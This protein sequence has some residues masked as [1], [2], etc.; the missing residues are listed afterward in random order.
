MTNLANQ[1]ERLSAAA[2]PGEWRTHAAKRG[3]KGDIFVPTAKQVQDCHHIARLFADK[4][5]KVPLDELQVRVESNEAIRQI[6]TNAALIVTLRNAVPQIIAA[7]NA[8]DEVEALRARVVKLEK[9]LREIGRE[10]D[11]PTT[12][13]M[14]AF[15]ALEDAKP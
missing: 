9:A 12:V 11:E 10:A 2:T 6:E 3:F 1:I 4:P 15:A 13:E 8:A 14:I 7:L 5:K